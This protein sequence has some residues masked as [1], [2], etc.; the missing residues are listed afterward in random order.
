M[1]TV[2]FI[3]RPLKSVLSAWQFSIVF[4]P[5]QS[6]AQ[7]VCFSKQTLQGVRAL[8]FVPNIFLMRS[9]HSF[10]N[11]HNG[12]SPLHKVFQRFAGYIYLS[13]TLLTFYCQIYHSSSTFR[14][15]VS[16]SS[17]LFGLQASTICYCYRIFQIVSYS[18]SSKYDMNAH[19]VHS[20]QV[21]RVVPICNQQIQV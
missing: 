7:N 19:D 14:Y 3:Q 6:L 18:L 10:K 12:I 5:V 9:I 11:Q 1:E 8:P 20:I 13:P 17:H 16:K 2:D 4:F 21:Q 15:Y